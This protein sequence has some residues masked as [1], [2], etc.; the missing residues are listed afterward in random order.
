MD[1]TP[2]PADTAFAG[3]PPIVA[4]GSAPFVSGLVDGPDPPQMSI[5]PQKPRESPAAPADKPAESLPG[6]AGGRSLGPTAA[7]TVGRVGGW[8]LEP[9]GPALAPA[10][11]TG[12]G[13]DWGLWWGT[14]QSTAGARLHVWR[15]S[16]NGL[17]MGEPVQVM[18]VDDARRLRLDDYATAYGYLRARFGPGRFRLA[19]RNGQGVRLPGT[20]SFVIA[21][22]E[23]HSVMTAPLP[24]ISATSTSAAYDRDTVV[25]IERMRLQAEVERERDVRRERLREQRDER[26]REREAERERRRDEDRR[27]RD[28]EDRRRGDRETQMQTMMVQVLKE[29]AG[30]RSGGK[31]D[32]LLAAV[33]AKIGQPDPLVLKL[34]D[35]HGKREELTDFFKVQAESMRMASTLQTDSLKQVMT[36]SQEV[37]SHLM[38]QAAEVAANRDGNGGWDGIGTVLSATANIIAALRNQQASA[39]A[40]PTPAAAHSTASPRRLV[41]LPTATTRAAATSSTAPLDAVVVSLRLARAVQQGER[42]DDIATLHSIAAGLPADLAVAIAAGDVA[43]LQ[44]IVLPAVQA[45]PSLGAWLGQPGVGDW[46]TGYLQRLRTELSGTPTSQPNPSPSES[47]PTDDDPI[48]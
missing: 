33:L 13:A 39:S 45:D 25:E 21:I 17:N 5:G 32:A 47:E 12:A 34:L 29:V 2:T 16:P 8:E 48:L 11:A 3:L 28:E 41:A 26:R 18:T 43:A 37:Q 7:P 14:F 35:T 31:E 6:F 27:R 36:A 9:L 23:E 10:S 4:N 30:G 24:A 42:I 38:R 44:R 19:P 40:V 20:Q 1:S 15:C 22:E 46:L